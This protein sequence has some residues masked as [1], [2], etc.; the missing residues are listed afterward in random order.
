M[1]YYKSKNNEVYAYDDEQ[2]AQVSHLTALEA[3]I[4]EK[5]T[6]YFNAVSELNQATLELN[7]AKKSFDS[8]ASKKIDE[9]NIEEKE[10]QRIRLNELEL[11]VLE[12]FK[13]HEE[14]NNTFLNAESEYFVIK[15]E[16]ESILP[17]VYEVR[18]NIQIMKKMTAK[19]VNNHVNPPVTQEQLVNNAEQQKQSLLNE[20]AEVIAPLQ[21]AV[22]LG[23]ATD[24]EI[25]HLKAWK[26]YSVL[27]NR[28]DTST[29]P[30]IDWPEKP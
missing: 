2:L 27:L 6:D 1:N 23:M 4:K 16:Y 10:K 7:G 19:E 15:N 18:E 30:D 28:I 13:L 22:D 17:V 3:I 26:K 20:A 21:Y 12:Q 5:E 24:Q 11:I 8:E 25:V 29:A 9:N 14:A